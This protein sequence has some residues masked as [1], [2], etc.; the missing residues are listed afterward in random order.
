M[1]WLNLLLIHF[2]SDGYKRFIACS[3]LS[4]DEIFGLK[5]FITG[6]ELYNWSNIPKVPTNRVCVHKYIVYTY[7]LCYTE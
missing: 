5:S 6:L 3:Q 7:M 1:A 2:N 4:I